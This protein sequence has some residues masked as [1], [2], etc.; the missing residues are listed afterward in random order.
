MKGFFG[1][2]V[3]P[4]LAA[5]SPVYKTE[6]IHSDAAPVI[7]SVNAKEIKDSYIIKF[8]QHVTENLAAAHHEWVQDLHLNVQNSKMELR[9]R[10]QMP[11]A[12]E[13]FEGLKHTYNIAGSLMG[14]S[15][16]FD[17]DVIEELRRH[18]DVSQLP[19][20]PC[21]DKRSIMS[22]CLGR[23]SRFHPSAS[24]SYEPGASC[25]RTC[26][27]RQSWLKIRSYGCLMGAKH[28]S[29]PPHAYCITA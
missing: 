17:E 12:D 29:F 28:S 14:Y 9:K 6:T 15:G 11:M 1:L 13:I 8:K 20:S 3:L 5:A 19:I 26:A 21:P 2:S 7:S 18:P 16:H 25:V 23:F 4:L 10:S 22:S 27:T 24:R